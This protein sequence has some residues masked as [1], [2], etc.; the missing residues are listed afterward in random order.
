MGQGQSQGHLIVIKYT[1]G[2]LVWNV[3]TK[4]ELYKINK[5]GIII[6]IIIIVR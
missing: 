2:L 1:R 5:K 3:Y 6:I 4:S